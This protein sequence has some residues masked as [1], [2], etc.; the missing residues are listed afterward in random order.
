[1]KFYTKWPEIYPEKGRTYKFKY[2]ELKNLKYVQE[3]AAV[4]KLK[5]EYESV[6]I[7]EVKD[8]TLKGVIEK[9]Y[10]LTDFFPSLSK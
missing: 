1:M 7:N 6:Y 9:Q 3:R 5:I 10:L 2:D 4:I 8:Q